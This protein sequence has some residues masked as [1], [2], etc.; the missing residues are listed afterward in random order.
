M[1][2][3]QA[4]YDESIIVNTFYYLTCGSTQDK[5]NYFKNL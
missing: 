4:Q 5:P 1:Y 3:E 2:D